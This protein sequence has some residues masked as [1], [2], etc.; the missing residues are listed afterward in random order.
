M[1][2]VIEVYKSSLASKKDF[3]A[4]TAEIGW[5]EIGKLV[6]VPSCL[7]NFQTNVK[8][9]NV[10]KLKTVPVDFKKYVI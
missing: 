7:N 1:R 8:H 3:I 10:D 4:L 6:D 9:L 5:L 2:D